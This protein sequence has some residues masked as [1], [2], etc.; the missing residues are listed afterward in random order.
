MLV[1]RPLFC[2]EFKSDWVVFLVMGRGM[3]LSLKSFTADPTDLEGVDTKFG[4]GEGRQ[5]YS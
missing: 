2:R 1:L 5:Y 4:L 3:R